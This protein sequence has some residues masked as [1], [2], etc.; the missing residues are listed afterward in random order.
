M[1]IYF[2]K[3]K[4]IRNIKNQISQDELQNNS[5]KYCMDTQFNYE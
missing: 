1:G 3:T 5:N 4:G 2:H